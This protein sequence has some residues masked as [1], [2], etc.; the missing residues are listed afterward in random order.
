MTV[1]TEILAALVTI[2][3]GVMTINMVVMKCLWDDLKQTK[4]DQAEIREDVARKAD[5][6]GWCD[7]KHAE[8]KR[9][10][11]DHFCRK[12]D[13]IKKSI[14]EMWDRMHHHS[15]DEKTGRV[16]IS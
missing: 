4:R 11:T 7:P 5:I 15:H 10:F 2:A 9:E 8:V 16:I 12:L 1:S 14:D 13:D 3:C 6:V